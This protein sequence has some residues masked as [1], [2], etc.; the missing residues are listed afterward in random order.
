MTP[1]A[2]APAPVW[3]RYL[4]KACSRS[5]RHPVARY[6]Q[7]ATVDASGAPRCRTVVVRGLV[8]APRGVWFVTDGRSG[9]AAEL[10]REPR[11]ELC[12]YFAGLRE[13]YRLRGTVEVLDAAGRGDAWTRLSPASRATFLWPPPGTPRTDDHLFAPETRGNSPVPSFQALR[14]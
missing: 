3:F 8:E 13:Q 10:D 14:L 6:A 2:D 9:K 4:A 5:Q 11:V 7:L 12:W 1:E